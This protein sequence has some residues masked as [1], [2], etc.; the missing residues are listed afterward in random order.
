MS[1]GYS[2]P[3]LSAEPGQPV[4]IGVA[5]PRHAR[6]DHVLGSESGRPHLAVS[7]GDVSVRIGPASTDRVTG[8]DARMARTL[9][10]QAAAY[11]AE[12]ERLAAASAPDDAAA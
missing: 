9:A 6:L 4:R 11:A 5:L 12:V 8:Q 10:D 1:D 3:T 2:Y 7:H